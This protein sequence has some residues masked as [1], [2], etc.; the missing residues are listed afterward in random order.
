[1]RLFVLLFGMFMSFFSLFAKTS[2]KPLVI[3]L[4]GPPGAGKG[5][6]AYPLSEKLHLPHISTGNLFRESVQ[7]ETTLGKKVKAY[8]NQGKLVADDL[9]LDLVFSRIQREDCKKGFILDG[10]PRTLYQAKALQQRA[11]DAFHLMVLH[12]SVSD[13]ILVERIT[14]RL[15]CQK[16][17]ASFHKIYA[18]P[19]IKGKC[20]YCQASLYQREDDKEQV[21]KN[22]LQV[23]KEQTQPLL[24]FYDFNNYLYDVNAQKSPP[25][26]FEELLQTVEAAFLSLY[27][28]SSKKKEVTPTPSS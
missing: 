16:C 5:T 2:E 10:F 20:D 3:I 6:H 12:F 8:L 18:L 7:Q 19:H 26:V 27:Q 21:I 9:V 23:Y 14:G 4:L 13:E 15:V 28:E 25:E 1:M 24:D 17:G 22:R 11:K